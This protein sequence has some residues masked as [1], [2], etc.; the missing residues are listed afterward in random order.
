MANKQTQP[1][2]QGVQGSYINTNGAPTIP[3]ISWKSPLRE[4][5]EIAQGIADFTKQYQSMRFDEYQ[6]KY[7][8]MA[9][10]MYHEM[11]DA[12]DPCE[13][14]DIKNK[15]DQMFAKPIDD[16]V[17]G[18]EYMNST[19]R[20]KW[21]ANMQSNYEKVYY[22]Q[23]HK[24]SAIQAE[25]K[26]NEMALAAASTGDVNA[27]GSYWD[28]TMV[29]IGNMQHLTVEQKEAL[30]KNTAK[31]FVSVMFNKDPVLAN[32]F[33]Q[34]NSK[35]L[36]KYGIDPYDIQDKTANWVR[37]QEDREYTKRLRAEKE[38]NDAAS[39]LAYDVGMRYKL[40][41]ATADEVIATEKRLIEEG[42]AQQAK[43]L[44]SI[45][46]PKNAT[47]SKK[48]LFTEN[49]GRKVNEYNNMQDGEEKETFK[50]ELIG[51]L[52]T[53]GNLGYTTPDMRKVWGQSLGITNDSSVNLSP[54]MQSAETGEL[55]KE[56]NNELS[57]MLAEGKIKKTTYDAIIDKND[58]NKNIGGYKNDI[59]L[60]NITT[61]KEIDN[62]P[63]T[64]KEKVELKEYRQ[65]APD[66]AKD[67]FYTALSQ[68]NFS[69]AKKYFPLIKNGKEKNDAVKAL[70]ERAE[71]T[72][73][74]RLEENEN[75]VMDLI[76]DG[77][78][79]NYRQIDNLHK[80]KKISRE[81]VGR[82]RTALDNKAKEIN[83]SYI[84]N[85]HNAII[86]GRI[87]TPGQ[88]NSIFSKLDLNTP[89]TA[90]RYK[91]AKSLFEKRNERS[92]AILTNA[93]KFVDNLVKKDNQ[94][95]TSV[96]GIMNAENVKY[97]LTVKYNDMM[98]NK[99]SYEAIEKAFSLDNVGTLALTNG[100]TLDDMNK[101][102]FR[103]MGSFDFN[104]AKEDFL[105]DRPMGNYNEYSVEYRQQRQQLLSTLYNG[106]EKYVEKEQVK[107]ERSF[108]DRI[109]DATVDMF[110]GSN[111]DG[112][113]DTSKKISDEELKER[114]NKE[115][116]DL[117]IGGTNG[118]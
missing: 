54:Y 109:I 53:A 73:K 116:I 78:I 39:N 10:N 93:M 59:L 49:F 43:I 35:V 89:D 72:V 111:D 84:S 7:D 107:K 4:I 64:D 27:I 92:F 106:L 108:F 34:Q 58:R 63:V 65:K 1:N 68:N 51:E 25:R 38:K 117:S 21:E 105:L 62:L 82:L 30:Q 3:Q 33:V 12:T 24:M 28:S 47:E 52:Q 100:V 90:K 74:K 85:I 29:S 14:Q 118:N 61:D 6:A 44:D 15:Y 46:F 80:N 76:A 13:L 86:D 18:K 94:G 91:E 26:S 99:A 40:G 98:E 31:N 67:K 69:E 97:I 103:K 115:G 71:E 110:T 66:H 55:T 96:T 23:M 5:P 88:I 104:A 36:A 83:D 11:A 77:S 70:R 75:K 102:V 56:Q 16:T 8:T 41:E 57:N 17:W 48:Q 113:N 45:V 95:T 32:S 87:T 42:N 20:R 79:S 81:A 19:Y 22:G 112:L 60:G 114:I 2:L 37:Q 50:Q 101:D 9:N